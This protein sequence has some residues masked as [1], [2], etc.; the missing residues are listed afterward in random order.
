M[1]SLVD[2]A[3]SF[4]AEL[5]DLKGEIRFK[6]R[7]LQVASKR[8]GLRDI[9]LASDKLMMALQKQKAEYDEN[10]NRQ[11]VVA[12]QLFQ[13]LNLEEYRSYS[14][15]YGLIEFQYNNVLATFNAFGRRVAI[16][17][18]KRANEWLLLEPMLDWQDSE[19]RGITMRNVHEAL[20]RL[21]E[22][23]TRA[24]EVKTMLEAVAEEWSTGGIKHDIEMDFSN[25]IQ[26]LDALLE[27]VQ[28]RVLAVE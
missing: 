2:I 1:G 5:E 21:E 9:M 4:S 28:E 13:L 14:Q 17:A 27:V 15:Q 6:D 3:A 16:A 8:I 19:F 18:Q 22:G 24:T 12:A 11:A 25:C 23:I 26:Q 7:L 20:E 10:H